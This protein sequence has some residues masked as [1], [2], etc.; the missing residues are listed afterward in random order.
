MA[1]PKMP[2]KAP[3]KVELLGTYRYGWCSCGGSGHQPF[4]DGAHTHVEGGFTPVVWTAE[5]S[6]TVRMCGCKRTKTPPYCDGTH[7]SL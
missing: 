3:Y 7:K 4:C 2:Q 1:D 6:E 5:K